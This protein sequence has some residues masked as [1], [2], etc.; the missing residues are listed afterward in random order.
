MATER[1]GEAP[2]DLDGDRRPNAR[3]LS[4]EVIDEALVAADQ[5]H[6]LDHPHHSQEAN[7][8]PQMKNDL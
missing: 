5:G 8:E 3:D 1:V 7:C 4:R 2:S 6:E